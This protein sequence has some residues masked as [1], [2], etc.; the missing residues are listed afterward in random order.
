LVD[1]PARYGGEE[2]TV[3]LPETTSAGA[4]I[5]AERL[6]RLVENSVKVDRIKVTIS[7]GVSSYEKSNAPITAEELIKQ[8]DEQLYKAKY[9]GRNKICVA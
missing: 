7:I 6:R 2:F 8:A 5:A 3:I 1:I 4:K 9:E